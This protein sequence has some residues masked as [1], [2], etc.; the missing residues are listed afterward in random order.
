MEALEVE[1]DTFLFRDLR[2]L[3]RKQVRVGKSLGLLSLWLSAP[4][5]HDDR[6][7]GIDAVVKVLFDPQRC[8]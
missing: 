2:I 3:E 8:F 1:P 5:W 6:A 7:V 4:F